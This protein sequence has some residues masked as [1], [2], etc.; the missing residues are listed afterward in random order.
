MRLDVA[1]DGDDALAIR[2]RASEGSIDEIV[3]LSRDLASRNRGL[4]ERVW[5]WAWGPTMDLRGPA[6]CFSYVERNSTE[7]ITQRTAAY[8]LAWYYE[9]DDVME[10]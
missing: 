8:M 2:V 7:I 6:A 5:V 3:A 4:A 10:A 9:S 1:V